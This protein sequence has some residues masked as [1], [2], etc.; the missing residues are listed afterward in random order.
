MLKVALPIR[1]GVAITAGLIAYFLVLALFGL[2]T[3]PIFSLFNGVITGFGIYESIKYYKLSK[4]KEFEYG[5]GFSVGIVTG[6]VSTILFTAFFAL[7]AGNI[8]PDYLDVMIGRWESTYDTSLGSVVFV[9]AI[10]GFAT[11]A[12]L[13]LSFMQLFKQ[14]WNTTKRVK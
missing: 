7:Y 3:N 9:V 10:M 12:V 6:F 8:N 2:H 11:S 4:G 1:F 14:S 13:T 5:D